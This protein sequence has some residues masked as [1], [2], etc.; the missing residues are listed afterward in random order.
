[1]SYFKGLQLTKQGEQLLAKVNGNIGETLIFTRG[2]VGAGEINSEDEIT[3]LTS[4]R[5]KW[6]ELLITEITRTGEKQDQVRIETQFTNADWEEAKI[7]REI[8][9]YAKGQNSPE[10]LFG[11]SN[12]FSK[13]D[14][15]PVP[16][17]NPQT[18]LIGI[19]FKISSATKV[20]AIINLS[21]LVTIEK[22]NEEL[23]KK[24]GNTLEI[25]V[26]IGMKGGGNL[27]N[28]INIEL[29]ILTESEI[30]GLLTEYIK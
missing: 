5:E 30:E 20:D 21:G 24:V 25:N 9:I 2:E 13:Y 18:F 7:L 11:Y 12:A 22:F 17:D 27:K 3:Y 16:Q 29:E 19:T 1:M 15:I 4:L 8:A 14:E 26:G 28:N 23:V 10:V 6:G